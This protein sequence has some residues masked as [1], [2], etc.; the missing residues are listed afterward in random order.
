MDVGEIL[1]NTELPT[2]DKKE[3]RRR[4]RGGEG[5]EMFTLNGMRDEKAEWVMW[6]VSGDQVRSVSDTGVV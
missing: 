5:L 1:N 4:R 6:R 2:T 3:R